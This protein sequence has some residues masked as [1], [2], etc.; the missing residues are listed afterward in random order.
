MWNFEKRHDPTLTGSHSTDLSLA[1]LACFALGAAAMYYLDP[2]SG[3]ER[4]ESLHQCLN[5]AADQTSASLADAS[6]AVRHRATEAAEYVRDHASSA[7][8]YVREHANSVG[9]Y[10]KDRAGDLAESAKSV[11]STRAGG[12]SEDD[13]IRE[14]VREELSNL[15]S[16]AS[17]VS[18]DVREGV[19]TLTG[20]L[21]A[22]EI[23]ALLGVINNI[24]GVRRLDNHL[25][26][27]EHSG[28]DNNT[29]PRATT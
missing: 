18:I 5:G 2:R 20:S 17:A 16:N 10:M 15:V 12:K 19:V 7:A 23:D 22:G 1:G 28:S 14:R 27:V 29:S 4:R 25:H 21:P 3:K 13:T 6:Q 8:G 9:G 11:V 24:R 26:T